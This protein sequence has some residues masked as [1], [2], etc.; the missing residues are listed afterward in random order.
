M[1]MI[2]KSSNSLAPIFNSTTGSFAIF[3]MTV[4]TNT[5]VTVA[6]NGSL[7]ATATLVAPSSQNTMPSILA[8]IPYTANSTS[9][10]VNV[11]NVTLPTATVASSSS[12]NA[13]LNAAY[14]KPTALN[15]T[16]TSGSGSVNYT[17]NKP[18]VIKPAPSDVTP[19]G[20]SVDWSY[21]GCYIDGVKGRIFATQQ[22]DL[23]ILTV[24]SCISTCAGLGYS[25][26]GMEYV[27]NKISTL[28]REATDTRNRVF[29]ASVT[30]LSAMAA[31]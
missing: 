26:A 3:P 17:I 5:S 12:S 11:V 16:V 25:V 7:P 30:T 13:T 4:A 20:I 6:L 19:L 24:E 23:S 31:P 18:T 8:P 10:L 28:L 9:G 14:T 21:K 15:G 22:P 29:N 2:A 27:S 1:T